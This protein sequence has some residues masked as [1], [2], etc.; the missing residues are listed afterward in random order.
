[1]NKSNGH[2]IALAF[3]SEKPKPLEYQ[4]GFGN[5]TKLD[6]GNGTEAAKKE[7]CPVKSARQTASKWLSKGN[8]QDA[9]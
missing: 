8:I 3:F 7:G 4:E 1:M 5:L 6:I 9:L 2:A